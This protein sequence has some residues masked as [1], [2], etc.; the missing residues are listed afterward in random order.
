M[1]DAQLLPQARQRAQAVAALPFAQLGVVA[2]R[3]LH[4]AQRCQLRLRASV[5]ALGLRN[6]FR[7]RGALLLELRAFGL[8]RLDGG[9]RPLH[10][11]GKL[12]QALLER[13]A[14]L[15]IGGF[16]GLELALQTL[17][18]LREA[19]RALLEVREV[20]LLELE[21][22]LRLKQARARLVQALLRGTECRLRLGQ[23]RVLL[24]KYFLLA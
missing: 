17:L 1:F 2:G 11:A 15:G 7:R 21:P 14:G 24:F 18:A 19:L 6:G 10:G 16:Q 20:G 8:E 13:A 12:A 4:L 5:L 22:P 3:G 9:L 23:K